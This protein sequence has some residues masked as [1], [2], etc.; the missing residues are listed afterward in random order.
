MSNDIPEWEKK[1]WADKQQQQQGGQPGHPSQER[2][3]F[4]PVHVTQD[5]ER[6]AH[7]PQ[8]NPHAPTGQWQDVDAMSM[9]RNNQQGGMAIPG[10]SPPPA[11]EGTPMV[12]LREGAKF[13][14]AVQAEKWGHTQMMVRS[15]GEV[16]GVAGREF[17]L[18]GES[19]CYCIDSLPVVNLSQV[20]PQLMINLVEV[21]AP[22]MGTILVERSAVVPVTH[23]AGPQLLRG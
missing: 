10:M 9:M 1:Y 7:N 8:H 5:R 6:N 21:S 11:S 12:M 4:E 23:N 22:F 18:K 16:Q 3:H 2:P 19:Q 13:Y 20:Y 17:Q 15:G 14:R